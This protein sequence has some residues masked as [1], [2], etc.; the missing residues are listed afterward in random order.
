MLSVPPARIRKRIQ[1]GK[2][3]S[4]LV[5]GVRWVCVTDVA[6]RLVRG[7]P[8]RKQTPHELD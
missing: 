3:R 1:R 7:R 2:V 6:R 5:G 4:H 8:T